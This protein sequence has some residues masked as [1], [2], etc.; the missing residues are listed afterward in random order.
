MRFATWNVNS[1]NVRQERVE[2]W[3]ADVGPD[4]VCMQET[5]LADDAFPP[6][7]FEALGYE[8]AHHGEG[9][10]NGVGDPVRVGLDDVV[11]RLRRRRRARRR[12][13]ADHGALRW[14][15]DRRQRLRAQRPRRSTPTTTST[16][17]AGSAGWRAHIDAR[18][19]AGDDA[20]IVAGDFNIAPDRRR[21]VRPGRVRRR[22][23]REP[24]RAR[25]RCG[26]R[27]IGGAR[28]RV[29]PPPPR[30][31]RVFSWW[32][33]RARRLPRGSRHAHRPRAGHRRRSP[34]GS[35][36]VRH[37][38]QRPQGHSSRATTPRWSSTSPTD[39]GGADVARTTAVSG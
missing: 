35:S 38:P 37:R 17:C 39:H 7:A 18:R 5:K 4:V 13:A 32:D 26:A 12:G 6:L 24:A 2:Q 15:L 8:S 16:S 36:W 22:H 11:D 20:V 29:P 30:R 31:E 21:R 33:Y 3:L 19:R 10:W 27:S 9:R 14:H 1:L 28:R 25:A 34:S 23:P